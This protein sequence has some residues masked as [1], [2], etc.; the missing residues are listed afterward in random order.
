MFVLIAL[1]VSVGSVGG[2]ILAAFLLG[3]KHR[4]DLAGQILE[5]VVIHQTAEVQHIGVVALAVQT[6]QHRYKPAA[7]GW[8]NHIRVAAHLHKVAPQAGQVF[9]QDQVNQAVAGILQHFQKSGPLKIAAAVPI[10]LIGLDLDPAVEHD[11]FGEDFILVLNAHRFIAGDIALRFC[12]IGGVIH[13]QAAVDTD[14]IL[15]RHNPAPFPVPAPRPHSRHS[16]SRP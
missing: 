7:K 15:L 12:G 11:E 10:V 13:T 3:M 16:G 1:A 5:V 6:I 9:D 4:L 2:K 8:E 14:F